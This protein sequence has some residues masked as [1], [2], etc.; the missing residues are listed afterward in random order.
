MHDFEMT[1]ADLD[2][3]V[4]AWAHVAQWPGNA[5]M[6]CGIEVKNAFVAPAVCRVPRD[7]TCLECLGSLTRGVRRAG[8]RLG[9][10]DE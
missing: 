7:V 3:I 4:H 9:D 5:F 10:D 2:G 6:K 1:W 8:L